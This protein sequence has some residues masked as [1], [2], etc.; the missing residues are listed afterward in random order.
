MP[1]RILHTLGETTW[2]REGNMLWSQVE[3]ILN[4]GS[5]TYQ[6]QDRSKLPNLSGSQFSV[7]LI[8]VMIATWVVVKT[9]EIVRETNP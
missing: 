7:L 8:G 2:W 6:L 3:M 5:I 1:G 9:D 4:L